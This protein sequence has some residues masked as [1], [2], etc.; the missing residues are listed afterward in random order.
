MVE[1]PPMVQKGDR[2]II[3]A[4]NK[5]IKITALGKVLEDGRAGDQVKVMNISSGKEIWATVIGPGKVSVTF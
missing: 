5:L 2:V 1:W 3:K 4:E